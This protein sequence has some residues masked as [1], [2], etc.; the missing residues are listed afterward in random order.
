M[1]ISF[2]G[3][4]RD[5]TGS[6]HLIEV[7]NTKILLDCGLFQGGEEQ[8]SKNFESFPFTP[9]DIDF[10]ILGH[11]HIDHSGRI[12]KLVKDGFQGKIISTKATMD[13][14]RI[15]LADSAKIQETDTEWENRKR[16]RAGKD[17]IEPL[18][19][20]GD[21][22]K[23][24]VY[25][26]PYYYDQ[27]IRL[28]ENLSIR[29]NDAGHILGSAITE[30]WLKEDNKEVKLVYAV[31]VGMPNRPILNDPTF[32][33]NADYVIIE[34][35]YG[36]RNHE[37]FETSSNRLIEV[38]RDVTGKGGTVIIPVFA[39]GR[40]QEL[41][42][43]FNNYFEYDPSASDLQNIPF[44]VDSPLAVQ[45]TEAFVQNSDSFDPKTKEQ[46]LRGDQPFEFENL[47]YIRTVEESVGLNMSKEPKVI[48]SSSG[49]ANAGRVRH[50][51]K[52]NIWDSKN[53][54]IFVGFQAQGTLGRILVDGVKEVK[55][56]GEEISVKAGIYSINGFSAH[57]DQNFLLEW[58]GR[59]K[60][61]PKNVF[62]VHGEEPASKALSSLLSHM[63]GMSTVVPKAG[64]SFE[65]KP[66]EEKVIE[67]EVSEEENKKSV[68]S[69]IRTVRDQFLT[70]EERLS[71][72]EM[73]PA[74]YNRVRNKLIEMQHLLMGL[75]MDSV[76]RTEGEE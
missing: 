22:E 19:T 64:M 67:R 52:H 74:E 29:F 14:S 8:E 13:L 53:A 66:G 60:N 7:G 69:E 61:T 31:D 58:M 46:I 45:A 43:Q 1:K 56:L 62:I 71:S 17:L 65:L 57:A 35:T 21:A 33:E 23:A 2:F 76:S 28:N 26:E 25:F 18:Y 50:H 20:L 12:P 11:A 49:M 51:L 75:N 3:A 72:K 34:S 63:Y 30:I 68:D 10:L 39:V 37:K 42:Y 6:N 32:I 70:L 41:I 4:T 55:I 27:L 47:T 38:I 54:V 59:L 36:D 44:Y 73:T 15:M 48:I 5:V 9:S 40:T 24:M 16:I